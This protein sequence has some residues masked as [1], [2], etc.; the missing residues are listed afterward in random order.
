MKNKITLVLALTVASIAQAQVGFNTSDPRATL[1]VVAKSTTGAVPEGLLIPRVDRLKAQTMTGVTTSTMIYVNNIANGST[2]GT[3]ANINA[4]GYYYF[5]GTV[6]V[7]INTGTSADTNIYNTN[8]TLSGNRIVM[9][10][11]FGLAFTP[12]TVDG[13]SVGGNTFSVDAA[14]SRIGIGTAAPNS[15][16][17]VLGGEMRVGGPASQTGSIPNPVL[18]IQSNANVDG[19]GGSLYFTENDQNYGYYLT[20]NTNPGA[21]NGFDG[22]GI[23]TLA[24]DVSN[25]A[26]PSIFAAQNQ[27][28]SIGTSTPQQIFHIDGARDNDIN[29]VPTAAQ[30]VNDVVVTN[31]GRVGVGTIDPS[32]KLHVVSP[33]AGAVRIVDGTQAEGSVLTSDADGVGTWRS[34]AIAF[35]TITVP[36]TVYTFAA[37]NNTTAKYTGVPIV[38][39][40]GKWLLNLTLGVEFLSSATDTYVKGSNFIR[41]RLGNNTADMANATFIADAI[42]PRL[43]SAGFAKSEMRG[44]V[45][46]NL[47]VN[48]TTAANKTYYL[49]VDNSSSLPDR[50][51]FDVRFDWN[52]SSITYQEIQ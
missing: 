27:N 14:N 7:K 38:L 29:T 43:A 37:N 31:V 42:Q 40:P 50:T 51:S 30:Q 49:F 13:F 45:S 33:T 3:A 41:F 12:T 18:R 22:I 39:P 17:Q 9:Q 47:A 5:D 48:N 52:E 8:G 15:K 23:G 20:H 16:L 32:V 6:W 4:V 34:T 36:S 10:N 24:A 25:L 46:G 35:R 11:A 26:R 21:T 28:V 19:S 1:D 44:M 2:G